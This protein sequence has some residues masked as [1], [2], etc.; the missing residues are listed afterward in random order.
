MVEP[1]F[2]KGKTLYFELLFSKT[3]FFIQDKH[4]NITSAINPP[5]KT[6]LPIRRAIHRK[7]DTK[8]YKKHTYIAA[9]Y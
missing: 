1:N 6:I 5:L 3:L 4:L 7:N 8:I 9:I 2:L